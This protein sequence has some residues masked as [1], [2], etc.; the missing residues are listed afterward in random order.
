MPN[1]VIKRVEYLGRKDNQPE[2][3]VFTD[4][5]GEELPNDLL[6]EEDVEDEEL[7]YGTEFNDPIDLTTGVSEDSSV[8]SDSKSYNDIPSLEDLGKIKRNYQPTTPSKKV[9]DVSLPDSVDNIGQDSEDN[10]GSDKLDFTDAY[11]Q[12]DL[13]SSPAR[14]QPIISNIEKP[15]TPPLRR[16]GRNRKPVDILD[17]SPSLT[18]V[19]K[20][21]KCNKKLR[22]SNSPPKRFPMKR[23][24]TPKW[25]KV[26]GGKVLDGLA[27]V[28]F[29]CMTSIAEGE[30]TPVDINMLD[31]VDMSKAFAQTSTI[32]D[33]K[34]TV[35]PEK[36]SLKKG[37]KVYGEK[38]H[39]AVQSELSQVHDRGVF[40]PQDPKKLTY[41]EIKDCLESHLF[42]EEKKNKDIKG[43]IVGGGKK[44]RSYVSKQ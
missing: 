33:S 16:S 3:L 21:R 26:Y 11:E 20:S 43:R 34:K 22:R 35:K 30:G 6:E 2:L 13:N 40:E 7:S 17:P 42:L 1:E 5:H 24:P 27:L 4:K 36:Y 29:I 25:T 28:Q 18:Q 38:G 9:Y 10:D 15:P 41:Q 32:G 8:D 14:R 39:A 12:V 44:Q 23:P 37:L 19:G 31:L